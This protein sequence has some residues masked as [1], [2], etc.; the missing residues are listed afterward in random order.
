M[1]RNEQ[2]NKIAGLMDKYTKEFEELGITDFFIFVMPI[3]YTI[4][5]TVE[6]FQR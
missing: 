3:D 5:D 2:N 1:N 6:E 4:K